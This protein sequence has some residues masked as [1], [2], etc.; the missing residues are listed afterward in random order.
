M[1]SV[2]PAGHSH[3]HSGDAHGAFLMCSHLFYCLVPQHGAELTSVVKEPVNVDGFLALLALEDGARLLLSRQLPGICCEDTHV[4][5]SA[6]HRSVMGV[7]K[8]S[9]CPL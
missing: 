3:V 5:A 1:S 7:S 9:S 8:P 6:R 2:S 4:T